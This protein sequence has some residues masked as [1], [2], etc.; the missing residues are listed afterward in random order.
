MATPP[1]DCHVANINLSG[2]S[3]PG[4]FFFLAL[5]FV[6]HVSINLGDYF[7]RVLTVV[8]TVRQLG[9]E[10]LHLV[11]LLSFRWILHPMIS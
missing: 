6:T 7:A 11:Q 9:W 3:F 10:R 4:S 2:T 5:P 8:A 1:R